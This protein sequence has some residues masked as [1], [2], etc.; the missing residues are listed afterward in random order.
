MPVIPVD[1]IP[2][3]TFQIKTRPEY[4]ELRDELRLNHPRV[5]CLLAQGLEKKDA[6][7]ISAALNKGDYFACVRS[8]DLPEGVKP[9]A[10]YGGWCLSEEEIRKAKGAL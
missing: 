1:Q 8:V 10:V 2:A 5:S 6:R 3:K 9:F 4:A 7:N